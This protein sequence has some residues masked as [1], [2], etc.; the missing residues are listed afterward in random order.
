MNSRVVRLLGL[1]PLCVCL[2][3]PALQA[4]NQMHPRWEIPGF[5]FRRNGGWRSKAQR[6]AAARHQL[7]ARRNFGALNSQTLSPRPSTTSVTGTQQV[8][9]LIFG[10]KNSPASLFTTFPPADFAQLL[11][12][13]APLGSNP[14][15]V[16]TFYEQ[17][18]NGAF[19]MQGTVLGWVQLDSNESFYTGTQGTCIGNPF[20]STSCNGIF[21]S[22]AVNAMQNGMRKALQK[23]D[24]GAGGINFA[25]FDNDGPDG[26]ANSGDDDGYVDMIMFAH[27][28]R[29]GACGAPIGQTNN[30]IWSHRFLLVNAAQTAAQDYITNDASAEGGT[31]KISDYFMASALGGPVTSCDS[32]QIM[33]IGTAAHEFGHAL[34]LPDLYDTGGATEGIGNWGLMGAGNF[35]S[36]ASPSRMEAWSLNELG[37]VTVAP[38]TTTGT[39]SFGAAPVADTAFVLTVQGSNPRNEYF[40]LENRQ[41]SLADTA[42]IRFMC[43]RSGQAMPPCGGGLLLWQVDQQKMDSYLLSGANSVNVG[44]IHGLR[45]MQADALRQLD[46]PAA[47][48]PR[49]RGDAGDPFPGVASN[50]NFAFR[51]N[52]A[53][54]K[55]VDSTFVGF[56]VDQITQVSPGSTMSFR[57]RFGSLTVVSAS[58][59]AATIQFDG[60]PFN[61]FRDLLDD[62]SSHDVS[63]ADTQVSAN[64]RTRWRFASW[65][66]GGARTHT[67]SGS[68]SGGTLT[69]N[70]N[71]D[72]KLIA[73]A[74]PGGTVTPDTAINLAGEFIPSGR[75]VQLTAAPDPS[76]SFFGW[77]G[78]TASAN[79][80]IVLPMGRP[81]T[82]TAN[83]GTTLAISSAIAR[84]NGVMG[85]A[86]LDTLKATGGTGT[87]TWAI[88]GTP[89]PAGLTLSSTGVVSG[90]PRATG[91]VSYTAQVT[92][93]SQTSS[94]TF[95]FSVSAPTLA[96]ASVVAQ[97]LGPTTPLNADQVRYLDYLGNVNGIFDIGDF[98]AWVKATGA[99]LSAAMLDALDRKSREG[100]ARP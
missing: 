21:S 67:I 56:A 28:S 95:T 91:N 5:D 85:A 2:L 50:N 61:V 66:D 44:P 92:S 84:P 26:V 71:R 70:L 68:L 16:R 33:P 15:S 11:F 69:A 10:Y 98:L 9:A 23:V 6:V 59:P 63:V 13:A 65:S 32:T 74:T 12:G 86:Y 37:W 1:V 34:G 58:D 31:I 4:Q 93:A 18:S 36:P 51:T 3:A 100:R 38:L 87:F 57:L 54:L 82:V 88:V 42:L 27:G 49:R 55:N 75:A 94:R 48:F 72:F 76:V 45:L 17:M 24:T 39:Y 78:D 41:A 97:L 52:P 25:Q 89:L 22:A 14:Y 96:T 73:N 20:G 77:T 35:T 7:L 60:A 90:F 99:P 30:H 83:F 46:D 29:D 81:Y 40:L 53:A 47:S 79:L 43:S 19:S 80:T 62:G 8:P 64:G